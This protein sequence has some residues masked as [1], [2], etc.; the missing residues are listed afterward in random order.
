[1]LEPW[2]RWRGRMRVAEA[3]LLLSLTV[4]MLRLL[5]FRHVAKLAIGRPQPATGDAPAPPTPATCAL[6]GPTVMA[7][8]RASLRLPF[9]VLCLPQAIVAKRMLAWRG[10]PT[11]LHL[12]LQMGEG[13][14]AHAWLTLDDQVILGGGA[15][16]GQVE[17][18]RFR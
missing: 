15:P 6:A 11:M 9:P 8:H 13:R 1:M 2:H 10:Q 5:P 4:L 7:V 17:I 12:S 18:A 14:A 3:A 16:T